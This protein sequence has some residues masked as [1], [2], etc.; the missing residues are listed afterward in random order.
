MQNYKILLLLFQVNDSNHL[1]LI[2]QEDI[3]E[4]YYHLEI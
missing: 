3:D 2:P 4:E 1:V